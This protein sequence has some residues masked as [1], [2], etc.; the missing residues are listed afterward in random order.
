[1]PKVNPF[2]KLM[3]FDCNESLSKSNSDLSLLKKKNLLGLIISS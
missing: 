1:M 2:N 3:L